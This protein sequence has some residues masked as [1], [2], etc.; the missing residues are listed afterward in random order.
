[1]VTTG[2]IGELI[3]QKYLKSK[4]YRIIECNW[5]TKYAEVDL[6]VKKGKVIVFV[7]VKTRKSER[8]ARPEDFINYK[9][10]QRLKRAAIGYMQSKKLTGPCRIDAICIVLDEYVKRLNHYI[11][12]S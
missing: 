2:K 1:M 11:N 3:A 6:I 7:E 5:R 9:K 12:I 8:F 4:G 10:K